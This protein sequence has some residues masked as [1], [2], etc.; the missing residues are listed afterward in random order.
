MFYTIDN[1]KD[2]DLQYVVPILDKKLMHRVIFSPKTRGN[3]LETIIQF[4]SKKRNIFFVIKQNSYAL[5]PTQT[6]L[7]TFY[8]NFYYFLLSLNTLSATLL[9]TCGNSSPISSIFFSTILQKSGISSPSAITSCLSTY[10]FTFTCP[11][12]ILRSERS[13]TPDSNA[14][15]F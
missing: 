4:L 11:L 10:T 5:K 15:S 7:Q 9:R 13:D 3:E 14:S 2:Y 12:S 6:T 8:N 1:K